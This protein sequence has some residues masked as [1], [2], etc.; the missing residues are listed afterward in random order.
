MSSSNNNHVEEV[1]GVVPPT[2]QSFLDSFDIHDPS[3]P[4]PYRIEG[5]DPSVFPP[6][7]RLS[8]VSD[9]CSRPSCDCDCFSLRAGETLTCEGKS[10]GD[11]EVVEVESRKPHGDEDKAEHA[12]FAEEV[13]S[14]DDQEYDADSEDYGSDDDEEEEE[15]E[16]EEVEGCGALFGLRF[17]ILSFLHCL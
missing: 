13:D 15:E 8:I 17:S 16:E 9:I 7:R 2:L 3:P 5:P 14:H 12:A 11:R 10:D 4:H 1:I 6:P